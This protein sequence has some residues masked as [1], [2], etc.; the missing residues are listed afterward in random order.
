MPSAR[1]G[2]EHSLQRLQREGAAGTGWAEPADSIMAPMGEELALLLRL[3][4]CSVERGT[5]WRQAFKL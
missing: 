3:Q 1:W 4:L 5:Q 2:D